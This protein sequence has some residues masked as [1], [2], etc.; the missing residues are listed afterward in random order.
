MENIPS[1]KYLNT[2]LFNTTDPSVKFNS[3]HQWQS[4]APNPQVFARVISIVCVAN[5]WEATQATHTPGRQ[6]EE[7]GPTL[8]PLNLTHFRVCKKIPLFL[9]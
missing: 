8:T 4:P 1:T 6:K 5:K 2:T 7:R 9:L 3:S